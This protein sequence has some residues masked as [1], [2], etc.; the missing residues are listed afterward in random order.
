MPGLDV[1]LDLGPIEIMAGV[2]A[3]L[4]T[5]NRHHADA[6]E[7]RRRETARAR[8]PVVARLI[9]SVTLGAGGPRTAISLGG[10]DPGYYWMVRRLIV[11]GV[12][13]KTAA[14]GTAELYISGLSAVQGA[15][16]TGAMVSGLALSD[17][18]DQATALPNKAFYGDQQMLLQ[19]Q[20][21]L[22]VVIDSGTA[23]QTYVAAAQV[24]VFRTVAA[25]VEFST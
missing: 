6:A 8:T 19:A 11:G 2:R 14:A 24:Q 15:G 10:P 3:E 5:L 4:A 22:L 7:H 1:D 25:E 9:S 12:T 18:V 13:W 23:A 20:E 16:V 21:N 17:L